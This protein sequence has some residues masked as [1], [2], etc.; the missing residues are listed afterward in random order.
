VPFFELTEPVP[1]LNNEQLAK[2]DPDSKVDAETDLADFPKLFADLEKHGGY[3][4]VLDGANHSSFTDKPLFSP[5]QRLGGDDRAAVLRR[6]AII[7]AYALAFFNETLRAQPAPLLHQEPS[8]YP[9]VALKHY[10]GPSRAEGEPGT[11]PSR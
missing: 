2:L 10:P 11:S 5:L 7:R 9:E 8:P 1:L 4:A 6:F 3:Y